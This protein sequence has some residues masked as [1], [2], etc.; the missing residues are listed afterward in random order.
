MKKG[1]KIWNRL[2]SLVLCLVMVTGVFAGMGMEVEAAQPTTHNVMVQALDYGNNLISEGNIHVEGIFYYPGYG[3]EV[4]GINNVT[5]ETVINYFENYNPWTMERY[6]H[7]GTNIYPH[8]NYTFSGFGEEFE[9]PEPGMFKANIGT[10][11]LYALRKNVVLN[12]TLINSAN[13]KITSGVTVTASNGKSCD[14]YPYKIDGLKE[15]ETYKISVNGSGYEHS[16]DYYVD[17]N[18]QKNRTKEVDVGSKQYK[19]T[20]D[21]LLEG[22]KLLNADVYA[23]EVKLDTVAYNGNSHYYEKKLTPGQYTVTANIS[24]MTVQSQTVDLSNSD[25]YVELQATMDKPVIEGNSTVKIGETLQLKIKNKSDRFSYAWESKNPSVGE[26]DGFFLNDYA[27]FTPKTFGNVKI[28]VTATDWFYTEASK[29]S[30]EFTITVLKGDPNTSVTVSPLT[31]AEYD[32]TITLKANVDGKFV[33][34]NEAIP[35]TANTNKE[36]PASKVIKDTPVVGTHTLSYTFTPTDTDKYNTTT[37]TI[38]YNVVARNISDALIK[39]GDLDNFV[40]DGQAKTLS[41]LQILLPDGAVLGEDDYNVTYDKNV[42]AGTAEV[43]ITGKGNYT[44]TKIRSFSIQKAQLSVENVTAESREY[45]GTDNVEITGVSLNNLAATDS[46]GEVVNLSN[47][48][49]KV[50]SKNQGTYDTVTNLTGII[51]LNNPNYVFTAPESTAVIDLDQ[52][53]TILPKSVTIENVAIKDTKVYDGGTVAEITNVGSLSGVCSID[54][55]KVSIVKGVANYTDKNVGVDKT[56]TFTGFELEGEEASNYSLTQPASQTASIT[57]KPLRMVEG[58]ANVN[59]KVY[60]GT[61]SAEFSGTPALRSI[62]IV[63]NDDV[64][65]NASVSPVFDVIGS[66]DVEQ[67]VPVTTNLQIT[68]TDAKNYSL[69]IPEVEAWITNYTAA[70][71]INYIVNSNDWINEDFVI[72]AVDGCFVSEG[73][74]ADS[75]WSD[76]LTVSC[77]NNNSNVGTKAFYVKDADGKISRVVNDENA[78]YKIDKIAPTGKVKFAP[79]EN[80]W[81][82]FINT[83]TFD[84]FYKDPQEVIIT[85]EDQENLS[86]VASVEWY[87]SSDNGMTLEEVKAIT[88]WKNY[89]GSLIVAL[90]DTK[91]F[92]YYV[93]ITD[94]A[95]N[96]T[97]L[98]T[99]GAVY[100]ITN[101]AITG[102]V[103]GET[104]YTTQVVNVSDTNLDQVTWNSSTIAIKP[105]GTV[106]PITLPGSVTAETTHTIVAIDKAGNETT[107]S[108]TMK[109]LTDLA[110]DIKDNNITLEDKAELE[111]SEAILEEALKEENLSKLTPQE[112]EEIQEKL[113]EIQGLLQDIDEVQNVIDLLESL[114]NAYKKDGET[115]N[116]YVSDR[117]DDEEEKLYSA[118]QAAYKA[119]NKLSVHQQSLISASLKRNLSN[120]RKVLTDYRIIDGDG[121]IWVY[122]T[123]GTITFT[124]NGPVCRFENALVDGKKVPSDEMKVTKGSTVVELDAGY[125][126]RLGTGDHTF[127][128]EYTDGESDVVEFSIVTMEEWNTMMNQSSG[129][130]KTGGVATGDSANILLWGAALAAGAAGMVIAKKRRKDEEA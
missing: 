91:K 1:K 77:D 87:E 36:I 44:G 104:Y 72:T 79:A 126:H 88:N 15:G 58:S 120:L 114:P 115:V 66:A 121:K 30:D 21:V 119:Y 128:V 124:A 116:P 82:D 112:K 64:K 65:I 2:L 33:I 55:G 93:K 42:D 10:V 75:V 6:I 59:D 61:T 106:D 19:L 127:Q 108:V 76:K 97:Y 3:A 37:G 111:K 130:N 13:E 129:V 95:G 11:T 90:E 5:R 123:N 38:E 56:V 22:E 68:G 41:N 25:K 53:V 107:V 18:G 17:K 122:N 105:D 52:S 80:A 96:V 63:G 69:Q 103:N 83:I 51:S 113:S 34:N 84:L 117:M 70:R 125:L 110:E 29:S 39:C 28:I 14:E 9:A 20:A 54:E 71:G 27:T 4:D 78:V 81:I 46:V 47:A 92:V 50:S 24:G 98:S 62:D 49:A 101:P 12:L 102:I 57:K 7:Y 60:D 45:N 8:Y 89:D 74:Q 67:F 23:N 48:T 99:D 85:A 100:D 73:S 40:Y 16:F 35:V 31:Y 26:V 86:G 109:P 32:E 118:V 43:T 94:N